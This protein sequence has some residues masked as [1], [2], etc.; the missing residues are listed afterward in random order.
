[1]HRC[2]DSFGST[3]ITMATKDSTPS[4]QSRSAT[5]PTG[6]ESTTP[7]SQPSGLGELTTSMVTEANKKVRGDTEGSSRF[8]NGSWQDQGASGENF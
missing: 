4:M 6:E 7:V 3:I 2:E 5:A 8:H 1:M